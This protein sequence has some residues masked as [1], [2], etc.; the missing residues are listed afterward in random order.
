MQ[1]MG[2][3]RAHQPITFWT[4][5]AATLAITGI[6]GFSGF[7]S[8]DEIL[9]GAYEGPL[10]HPLIFWL[11]VFTA[12]MTAFY[13]FRGLLLTF[14]GSSRVEPHVAS[15]VHES[16]SKMTR[17]L[18]VLAFFSVAAGYLSWPRAWGGAERFDEYL[19]PVFGRSTALLAAENLRPAEHGLSHLGIMGVSVAAALMGI[20]IA[21]WF[22][23]KSTEIPRQLAARFEGIYQLL[24]RKYYV[25]E[26]YDWLLVNPIK[27]LSE[28]VLWRATDAAAIDGVMVDGTAEA[29][30]GI[31]GVLRR[32]QSGNL[33]S[34]ATWVLLGAVL[35]LGY[36]L[37]HG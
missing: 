26:A 9:V 20:G 1:K 16:S 37:F 11:A 19:E 32:I 34:Y 13:M 6:P 3:L 24:V 10:G 22:Y 23:L 33:R 21:L 17:P 8:K 12:A 35:W 25:D 14:H 4:F 5:V 30:L 31:G 15:H 18:I 2:G 27:Y 28:K 36:V 7:F 29:T